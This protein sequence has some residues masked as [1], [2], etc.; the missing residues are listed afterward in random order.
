MA[1]LPFAQALV[2]GAD[3]AT[4]A[5]LAR[6]LDARGVGVSGVMTAAD[7]AAGRLASLGIADAVVPVPADEVAGL[8]AALPG[9]AIFG[10]AGDA[11]IDAAL[12]AA[13]GAGTAEAR[14][15]R[16]C[17]IADI[18]ALR[19]APALVARVQH[20]GALRRDRG[21]SF[22]TAVLHSHDSR[23]ASADTLPGRITTAAFRAAQPG[24][25]PGVLEL[26]ETGPRDW[27]WTPEYVDAVIRLAALDRP[28]DLAI[29]SGTPL[30][31]ADFAREAFG[32]FGLD[33]ADHVRLIPPPAGAA[34]EAPIDRD[35]LKAAT[36]W[37]AS[38]TG[39][40]LVRALCEGAAGRA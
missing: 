4:G 8:V 34:A 17:Q 37:Q 38:T 21:L 16:F 5:Y 40:D 7:D 1:L 22:A 31:V 12:S 27:G 30:S 28:V 32:F 13:A 19:T 11:A 20:I 33:S 2:I 3:T 18:D 35:R 39:R 6:L 10:V 36:G 9:I 15:R 25:L 23:L 14:R 24:G 26:V 29:G